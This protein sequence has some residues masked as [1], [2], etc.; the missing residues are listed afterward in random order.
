MTVFNVGQRVKVIVKDREK[1]L[2]AFHGDEYRQGKT[3]SLEGAVGTI[4]EVD[5]DD[6]EIPPITVKLDIGLP[7]RL[8]YEDFHPEELEPLLRE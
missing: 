8:S 6:E 3:I 5:F 2:Y 7:A 1:H 4:T